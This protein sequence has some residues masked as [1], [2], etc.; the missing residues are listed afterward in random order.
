MDTEYDIPEDVG[1]LVVSL[2]QIET[3]ISD[4]T[5]KMG[6]GRAIL[7]QMP[8]R[9]LNDRI[10]V[11]PGGVPGTCHETLLVAIG[12]NDDVENSILHAVEHIGVRCRGITTNVLFWAASWNAA[13]WIRHRDSFQNVTAVL[14][15]FFVKPTLLSRP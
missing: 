10:N 15:L 7:K 13:S 2:S 9:M 12:C 1:M 11:F 5:Q 4:S 14:K 8:E 3:M 6:T